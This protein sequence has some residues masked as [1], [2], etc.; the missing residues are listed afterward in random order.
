MSYRFPLRTRIAQ[1]LE[2]ADFWLFEFAIWL[3]VIAKSLS[4]IFIPVLL[5]KA[6]FSINA[7]V[8]FYAVLIG[9]DI[10]MNLF[11]PWLIRRF[12]ARIVIALSTAAII[13][14]LG[15]LTFITPGNWYALAALA[16]LMAAYDA[17]YWISH[18][19]LFIQSNSKDGDTDR[20][21]GVLYSV[22]KIGNI[23]GPGLG[24]VLLIFGGKVTLLA[25]SIVIFV[26][27]LIPLI[28]V[29]DFN[30]KPSERPWSLKRLLTYA[31]DRKNYASTGLYAIPMHA[32]KLIW[33][34]FIFIAVGTIQSVALVPIILSVT[35]IV[36]TALTH[37][38]TVRIRE[39][40][41]IGGAALLAVI[42][43]ARLYIETEILFYVSVFLAGLCM[44]FISIPLNAEIFERAKQTDP[45]AAATYRNM[46]SMSG[47]FV[48]FLVLALAVNVFEIGFITAAISLLIL[49]L[50]N[51]TYLVRGGAEGAPAAH[52]PQY[53]LNETS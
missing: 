21:T 17:L 31:R 34:L 36:F 24:A 51:I 41:I 48:L 47:G 11:V 29:D 45:L 9:I 23:I 26:L 38:H 49:V 50:V 46:V 19:Y 8:V 22:K 37:R 4:F 25:A 5:L 32:E 15:I 42:W 27:S 7:V 53:D 52:R 30:D 43:I 2:H 35:A 10:P 16:F 40:M 1:K 14:V 33:P 18:L 3:H 13:G 39:Y 12:G 28:K 44:L 20:N 6:G